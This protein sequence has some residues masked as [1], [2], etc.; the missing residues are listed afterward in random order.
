M[1]E[2]DGLGALQVGI[3]GH[4][5][6]LVRLGLIGQR[7]DERLRERDDLV[8]L[9]AQIHAQV[10]RDLIVAAA[11][12]VQALAG[13]ADALG[14]HLLDEHVDI[15]GGRVNLQRAGFEIV[16][17]RLQ[18]VDDRVRVGLRDDVL[19]A[20]HGRVRHGAGDI[21]AVHPAVE[22]D[23][24]VEVVRDLAGIPCRAPGPEL[25]H[26]RLPARGRGSAGRRG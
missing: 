16:Q 21:L 18:A 14:E 4:D 13:V 22:P 26:C 20:E 2:R 8:R 19:R 7:R 9:R 11:G 1:P 3:A 12:G 15:L 6:R 5:I 10:E 25:T 23:G 17:D 24:G